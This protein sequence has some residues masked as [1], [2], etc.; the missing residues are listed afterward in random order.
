M[1]S[2]EETIKAFKV[3]HGDL[4]DYSLIEDI[5]SQTDKVPIICKMH[6]VF[7]QSPKLH[8]RG[9]GC[10]TCAKE[11]RKVQTKHQWED[12][13]QEAER[14][15]P[16]HYSFPNIEGEYENSHSKI[17]VKCN[18]DG[19]VFVKIA[20]DFITSPNGGCRE[21]FKE[22]FCN[23]IT[24]DELQS[25]TEVK[26]KPFEGKVE[27]RDKVIC[28]C[29]HHGEYEA[30]VKTLLDG[31]GKCKGCSSRNSKEDLE[32]KLE[33]LKKVNKEKY[34][35]KF[36]INYDEFQGLGHP[37][38]MVCN[39]CGFTFK[40]PPSLHIRSNCGCLRCSLHEHGKRV[41]KTNEEF[42]EQSKAIFG[43]NT[44]DYSLCNYTKSSEKVT[45]I[46]NECGRTFEVEANAH[47][48]REHGCPYHHRNRSIDE[49]EIY[50]FIKG[51]YNKDIFHSDRTILENRHELDI[52]IP[53]EK[54]AVEYDGIFWHNEKCKP[55][56]Y[57]INKTL[58]CEK[59]GIHLIHIFEDE[60][61]NP[62]KRL[63]W[64][65]MIKN[66][67][68]KTDEKIYARNCVVM[69]LD[70]RK[71]YDFL[72]HNHLQGKCASRI[73]LGL[74]YNEELVSV[75]TFGSP[76]HFIGGSNHEYELLRF[77][78]KLNTNVIG[79][80]GKLFNYFLKTYNPS[81][82]VSYADRRWSTG[83]LYDS[84]GFKLYN[85]S[86]PNY[87]YVVKNE[88][89]NRF[90]FRKSVLMKKYNCPADMSEHEFCKQHE[91]YR[92]YDCGSLC[93]EWKK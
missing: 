76:R 47:L 32:E 35:N 60:W 27:I 78:S 28:I 77:C 65:S 87:Y 54:L 20:C 14:R 56:N 24:Y 66:I 86:R 58:E 43:E 61:K 19:N 88:R 42:I 12:F 73:R 18:Y 1:L 52:Y 38:T 83:N 31:R 90:N 82:I 6:G 13:L 11:K 26:V 70:K 45:L 16:G 44:F 89:K 25:K 75:M 59:Q 63:I 67:L 68:H 41:T 48:S 64:K 53:E 84:L 72:N 22:T 49:E 5:K 4:Y 36:T 93:Y 57:H 39:D 92:I 85:K 74:Y 9:Q 29:P 7:Y 33:L 23:Y 80:A 71:C 50:E 2:K 46:C 51:I 91:W 69:E 30:L 55:K 17:T 37:V 8:K 40:R 21:C 34:D 10:P 81:S 79:G 62:N 15:F 3:V